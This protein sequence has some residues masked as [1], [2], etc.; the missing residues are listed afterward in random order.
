MTLKNASLL[1]LLY[2]AACHSQ[3]CGILYG[4]HENIRREWHKTICFFN[5]RYS[6]NSIAALI[7]ASLSIYRLVIE[8]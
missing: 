5:V 7:S 6:S 2:N 8:K 4:I 1:L 3:T